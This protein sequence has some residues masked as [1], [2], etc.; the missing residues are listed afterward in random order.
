MYK[1]SESWEKYILKT[2]DPQSSLIYQGEA[3]V[4]LKSYHCTSHPL[5]C[6]QTSVWYSSLCAACKT[7]GGLS[8]V[9]FLLDRPLR[10]TPQLWASDALTRRNLPAPLDFSKSIIICIVPYD[11]WVSSQS[12][13]TDQPQH[14]L[15]KPFN[16]LSSVSLHFRLSDLSNQHCKKCFGCKVGLNGKWYALI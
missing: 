3:T 14:S 11:I 10:T 13:W 12:I 6:K 2:H 16:T 1:S 15:T 8:F 9:L 7:L 4:S 5:S